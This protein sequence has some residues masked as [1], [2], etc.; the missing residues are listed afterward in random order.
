MLRQACSI[1]AESARACAGQRA[2]TATVALIVAAVTATILG[3]TGQTDAVERDVIDR[4]DQASSRLIVVGDARGTD[5]IPARVLP[6]IDAMSGTQWVVGLGSPSDGRNAVIGPGGEAVAFRP[7]HGDLPPFLDDVERT[8]QEGEALVGPEAAERLGMAHGY[9][10]V[11]LSGGGELAVVGTAQ[12][13]E[14][15]ADLE[16]SGLIRA[17]DDPDAP[18]ASLHILAGSTGDVP[19]LIRAVVALIDPPTPEDLLVESPQTLSDLRAVV[20]GD[21]GRFGRELL[22]AVLA[23]GAVLVAGSVFGQTLLRRRDLGRRRALGATRATLMALLLTQTSLSAVIGAAL[24]AASGNLIVDRLAAATPSLGFVV[25]TV[26]LAVLCAVVAA[27]PPA[28]AAVLRDPI[29]VL[30]KP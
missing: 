2:A 22:F 20:A 13:P 30:R 28:V 18:I 14:S 1:I 15:L 6:V 16:T 11:E 7:V 9:G 12:P 26:V 27:I 29:L 21:L 23:A 10:T 25:A 17:P 8:P 4:I 3:T 5:I 24:G 19:A